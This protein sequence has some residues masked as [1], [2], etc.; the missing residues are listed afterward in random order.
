[1]YHFFKYFIYILKKHRFYIAFYIVF[2]LFVVFLDHKVFGFTI[3]SDNITYDLPDFDFNII[4]NKPYLIFKYSTNNYKICYPKDDA[5]TYT[6]RNYDNYRVAV[7]LN[8]TSANANGQYT[9][10]SW[11]VYTS[12]NGSDWV[13]DEVN[14]G[15]VNVYDTPK[16]YIFSSLNIYNYRDNNIY[17]NKSFMNPYFLE[18]DL[19][20]SKLDFPAIH[21]YGGSVPNTT[22]FVFDV[23]EVTG[24]DTSTKIYTLVLNKES[25]LYNENSGNYFY[26]IPTSFFNYLLKPRKKLYLFCLLERWN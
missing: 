7:I 17:F 20:F 25:V 4:G 15:F 19:Q 14:N 1:M 5:T 24:S 9:K 8:N 22:T 13:Y 6:F 12:I 11:S 2:S 16:T 26:E 10:G 3:T 21:L 23:G 18:T